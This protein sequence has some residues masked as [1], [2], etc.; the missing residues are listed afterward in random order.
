MHP[1]LTHLDSVA[2]STLGSSVTAELRQFVE[3]RLEAQAGRSDSARRIN[4][5]ASARSDLVRGRIR[6]VA[7]GLPLTRP[8]A[9]LAE[10][11]HKR[12]AARG[13]AAGNWQVLDELRTLRAEASEAEVNRTPATCTVRSSP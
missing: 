11:V 3:L 12:L 6:F 7:Q 10:I 2:S 1:F 13:W 4:E 9:E 5:E 8:L